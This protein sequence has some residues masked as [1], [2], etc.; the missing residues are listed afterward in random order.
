MMLKITLEMQ[1]NM[2]T[3]KNRKTHVDNHTHNKNVTNNKMNHHNHKTEEDEDE[4]GPIFD[5][6]EFMARFDEDNPPF[7][8]PAEIVDDVDNDFN[9]EIEEEVE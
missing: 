3:K 1:M 7:D 5:E 9:V 4:E 2:E 8:I 6:E